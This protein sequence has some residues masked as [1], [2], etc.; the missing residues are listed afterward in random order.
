MFRT[1]LVIALCVFSA[2][3]FAPVNNAVGKSV[4]KNFGVFVG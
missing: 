1:L 4:K 2:S 3:A